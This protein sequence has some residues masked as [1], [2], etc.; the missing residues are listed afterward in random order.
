VLKLTLR[1]RKNIPAL[2]VSL[3]FVAG[4]VVCLIFWPKHYAKPESATDRNAQTEI[5]QDRTAVFIADYTGVLALFTGV[6]ATVSAVSN[7]LIWQQILLARKEFNATHR[8]KIITR[9][10]RVNTTE[11]GVGLE[12]LTNVSFF[13]ANDGSSDAFVT[14]IGT[15]VFNWPGPYTRGTR[16]IEFNVR[17]SKSVLGAGEEVPLYTEHTFP[18]ALTLVDRPE[19]SGDI[20]WCIGYIKYR[21]ANGIGRVTGFCRKWNFK[22]KAWDREPDDDWEYSY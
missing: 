10:F 2:I 3:V 21:D 6:L 17:Q 14:E 19:N 8:P 4:I 1:L 18:R 11:R 13:I 9:F 16:E 20:W 22:T 5:T 12:K 15:R 7:W